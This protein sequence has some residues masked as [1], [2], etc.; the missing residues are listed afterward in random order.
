MPFS[1]IFRLERSFLLYQN[2][3]SYRPTIQHDF[4]YNDHFEMDK[5]DYDQQTGLFDED[6]NK[7]FIEN[8][9]SNPRFHSDWCSMIYPQLVLA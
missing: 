1:V 4:I 9:D 2:L 8:N 6:E 5:Q 3:H 7:N